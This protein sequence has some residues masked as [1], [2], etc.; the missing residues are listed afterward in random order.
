MRR[1]RMSRGGSGIF[2]STFRDRAGCSATSSPDNVRIESAE[3][4]AREM[5]GEDQDS[6][7]K[8]REG[9]MRSNSTV[10]PPFLRLSGRPGGGSFSGAKGGGSFRG[11]F[12][13]SRSLTD[14]HKEPNQA[15][16][17]QNLGEGSSFDR[18][19][20]RSLLG[21]SA[22]RNE[23]LPSSISPPPDVVARSLS[24]AGSSFGRSQAPAA[25]SAA[26]VHFASEC[27]AAASIGGD[28]SSLVPPSPIPSPPAVDLEAGESRGSSSPKAPSSPEL[29]AQSSNLTMSAVQIATGGAAPEP[30]R[31][32]LKKSVE[33]MA[34][35]DD[36]DAAAPPPTRWAAV[37]RK[38]DRVL[39]SS[40]VQG[41]MI[42]ITFISLFAP[43]LLLATGIPIEADPIFQAAFLVCLVLFGVEWMLKTL[44]TPGYAFGLYFL[45]DLIATASLL[46]DVIPE[47]FVA[48]FE[49]LDGGEGG[50]STNA[51]QISVARA[52]R[53]A[54][55]GSRASRI[56]RV[57]RVVRVVRLARL[58]A[59]GREKMQRQRRSSTSI[60][61]DNINQQVEQSGE[62][63]L[64][65]R[66]SELTARK[67][68][69]SILLVMI[70]VAFLDTSA[71][72]YS[73]EVGFRLL[74]ETG[75][76]LVAAA[77][78]AAGKSAEPVVAEAAAAAVD[79]SEAACD[80]GTPLRSS[81]LFELMYDEYV[82][83][84]PNIIWLQFAWE[85]A[86]RVNE[87][88]VL[89]SLRTSEVEV[90]GWDGSV[91]MFNVRPFTQTN[92]W[93]DIS[94]TV[95]IIL[96]LGTLSFLIS[97][98]AN[99]LV[100]RPIERLAATI[101]LFARNPLAKALTYTGSKS[102]ETQVLSTSINKIM[103]LLQ[104][105][106]GEAGAQIMAQH[107]SRAGEVDPLVRGNLTTAIFGF[108]DIRQFSDATECL[109][110]EV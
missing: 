58:T 7:F 34:P 78:D 56:V 54:R 62:S 76:I 102:D 49:S 45:L 12:G 9:V 104:V 108:C 60:N 95:F 109:Q 3:W 75:S 32:S 105:G 107:L 94:Q 14:L 55:I 67:V 39:E 106:L 17:S 90:L 99:V 59:G 18:K 2:A 10:S 33:V 50:T 101:S 52:S 97:R 80:G 21:L 81:P 86:A 83:V 48:F 77:A 29:E 72:D 66:I 110:E 23:A 20:L 1:R 41:V 53:T 6:S 13:R 79:A 65:R 26:N 73:A 40:P 35:I 43:D 37:R 69:V 4:L 27:A 15:A 68:I 36:A 31:G 82:A 71:L 70:V 25:L 5:A 30:R 93:L 89:A 11:A 28:A 44:V 87:S 100:I 19:R 64:F 16:I 88:A 63:E 8:L 42:L 84:R 47:V 98:D 61:E 51:E 74:V 38:V 22:S 24:P 85:A 96:M 57:V 91:V 92:A 103:G 46:F